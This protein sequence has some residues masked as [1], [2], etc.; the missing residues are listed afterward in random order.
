[1]RALLIA[2]RLWLIPTSIFVAQATS[3][4][5]VLQDKGIYLAG[6]FE[7]PDIHKPPGASAEAVFLSGSSQTAPFF[8]NELI[9][10][11]DGAQA[12]FSNN[13][14]VTGS[15]FTVS[16]VEEGR[17]MSLAWDLAGSGYAMTYISVN[18]DND[19]YHVYGMKPA[20]RS[21]GQILVSGN[22]RD[23]IS[24][25]HFFGVRTVP[26]T[27]TSAMMLLIS[28]SGLGFLRTRFRDRQKQKR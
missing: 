9:V 11:A 5:T 8:L 15:L 24:H 18:F 19:F 16:V 17:S 3:E 13:G 7:T 22:L 25:I 23:V 2:T 27:G 1:M 28:L 26:E 20:F 21:D 4:A 12:A 14:W 10:S 6:P